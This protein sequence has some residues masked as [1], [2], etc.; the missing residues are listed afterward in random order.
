MLSYTADF[1]ASQHYR[2]PP[3]LLRLSSNTTPFTDNAQG[4]PLKLQCQKALSAFLYEQL[5]DYAFCFEL[6]LQFYV[7]DPDRLPDPI[8]FFDRLFKAKLKKYNPHPDAPAKDSFVL[9]L[10]YTDAFER[11]YH[12][13]EDVHHLH[14]EIREP[15]N[16]TMHMVEPKFQQ[17]VP[18]VLGFYDSDAASDYKA[19]PFLCFEKFYQ[20]IMKD[21][22]HRVYSWLDNFGTRYAPPLRA[23]FYGH[24]LDVTDKD[25]IR[26]IFSVATY[27]D[28]YCHDPSVKP[29]YIANLTKILG[30]DQL[31]AAYNTQKLNFPPIPPKNK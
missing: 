19:T 6:Y 3:A 5:M 15:G 17:A 22:G 1:M 12:S 11:I 20:R 31:S 13:F 18:I 25:I 7:L 14:G 27:V 29:D 9:S 4:I 23:I 8:P 10:N 24:S 30:K 21:T 2:F 26:K 16:L 28:I